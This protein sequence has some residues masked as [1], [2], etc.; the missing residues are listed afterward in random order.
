MRGNMRGRRK[1]GSWCGSRER[2]KMGKKIADDSQPASEEKRPVWAV[3]VCARVCKGV[4]MRVLPFSISKRCVRVDVCARSARVPSAT[5]K[6]RKKTRPEKWNPHPPT[7][8]HIYTLT[9]SKTVRHTHTSSP[10][11]STLTITDPHTS[12]LQDPSAHTQHGR[13]VQGPKHGGRVRRR[14]RAPPMQSMQRQIPRIQVVFEVFERGNREICPRQW[15]Q[16]RRRA[17]GDSCVPPLFPQNCSQ[18]LEFCG[19]ALP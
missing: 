4:C 19:Q 1:R 15:P 12:P 9:D 16:M 17:L 5:R 13:D 2:T 10:R 7:G 6:P 3:S 14:V 18:I 8:P 11:P